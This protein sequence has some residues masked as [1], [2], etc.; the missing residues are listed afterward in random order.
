M[1]TIRW[2]IIGCGDVTE[3]KSGPG[4][5]K[6]HN[7]T[8]TAVMRRDRAK[9]EDY[10][11]RHGVPRA[12]DDAEALIADADVDAVYVATPPS[13]H[14]NFVL[15]CAAAGKPVLVEKPMAPTAADARRMVDACRANQVPLF[16]AYYRRALPRFVTVK[17]IIDSGR[18]GTVRVVEVEHL[19]T[20][21]AEEPG[22]DLPWRF[23]PDIAGGGIFVDM[24]CHTLDLLDF[25][26]GPVVGSDGQVANQA[27]LYPAED[28]VSLSLRFESGVLGVGNW[29][30]SAWRNREQTRIIGTKGELTLSLFDEEP[31]AVTTDVGTEII[32]APNPP[33][34][35]QPLIQTVVDALNGDGDC[36]STGETG[37]RT[38]VV[39]DRVLADYRRSTA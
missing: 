6:A 2:G 12:Y 27:G 34:V 21:P 16:T 14:L 28:A 33:H 13:A 20:P 39:L 37:L 5:Q 29:C 32:A 31:L 38:N 10:A 36:P 8:L 22:G 4:F 17:Q 3:V 30:F 26:F 18:I 15:L 9:A 1:T 35:H 7:S 25:L 24:G 11:R 19:Q 23:R